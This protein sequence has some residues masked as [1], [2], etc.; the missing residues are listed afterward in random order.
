[1]LHVWLAA[2]RHWPPSEAEGMALGSRVPWG[3]KERVNRAG[4]IIRNG[5]RLT[6][7]DVAYL[8]AWRGSHRYV[9]NTFQA[10]LR[11]KTRGTDIVVAQRLKRRWTIVDKLYREPGMRLSR[12]DDVAGCRLIF[13]DVETL[14]RFRAEFHQSRFKHRRKNNLDKYDYISRPKPLGYRGVH[15]IYEYN[16]KST[17]GAPYRGLLLELQYRT[18]CQHAWATCVE[19]VTHFTG[20]EPKFNRGDAAHIEFFKLASELIAR[21]CEGLP[22]CY[23]DLTDREVIQKLEEVDSKIH[24]MALLRQVEPSREGAPDSDFGTL[25]L[26][27]EKGGNLRIHEFDER[28]NAVVAY[29][30]LEKEFPQDDIVLVSGE[31][32]ADIRLSYKN[33]FSDVGEFVRLVDDGTNAMRSGS[34][35]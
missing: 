23:P 30:N 18:Q 33:Y 24:L 7:E 29:F 34:Y 19:I 2:S 15:D 4:D 20:H 8:D 17:K 26:Q 12:M 11:R 28:D 21:T 3:S 25:I 9:L 22:S 10:I 16:S 27:I 32:F 1:M 14:A 13:S 31:T 6:A 5:G 35:G